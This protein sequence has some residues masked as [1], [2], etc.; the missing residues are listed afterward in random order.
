MRPKQTGPHQ[1]QPL[2]REGTKLD[3]A[4]AAVLMLH[5]RGS[6]AEDILTLIPQFQIPGFAFVAPQAA[7]GTWYPNSFLV[8]LVR[9]EP[10]LSSAL[11]A[12]DAALEHLEAHAI[13]P[14]YVILMGFSQGACLALEFAAR[15]ARKFGGI[16]GL[17]GGLIGDDQTPRDYPGSFA[18]TP[19]FLGCSDVDPHVPKARV[20]LSAEVFQR[21][22]ADVTM[23]LFPGMAHTINEDEVRAVRA[24]MAALVK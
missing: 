4:R 3:K 9:N 24:M 12:V 16:A 18:N 6:S 11:Q 23:R 21:M 7:G 19:V 17:S 1:G 5:G 13:P 2:L 15:N 8:P 22:D 20:E 10:Y 14:E